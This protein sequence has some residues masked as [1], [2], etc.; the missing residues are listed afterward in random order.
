[1]LWPQQ[2]PPQDRTVR[3]ARWVPLRTGRRRL[4][5][6]RHRCWP[7]L[8]ALTVR[9]A[10]V[11]PTTF[12]GSADGTVDD[13]GTV[14][15]KSNDTSFVTHSVIA[16][17]F[18]FT[19][20]IGA[21]G[22]ITG[23]G[24]GVFTEAIYDAEGSWKEGPISCVVG[25]TGLPFTAEVSGHATY[26]QLTG[27]LQQ[28]QLNLKLDNAVE[29]SPDQACG[30]HYTIYAGTSTI[31][32]DSL[33]AS[34]QP[35]TFSDAVLSDHV[36]TSV[37]YD[38]GN[39]TVGSNDGT[40][41]FA[42]Q[43]S[44]SFAQTHK[45]AFQNLAY[46]EG[47]ASLAAGGIAVLCTVAPE[48]VFS[49]ACGVVF[50][51]GM[52]ADGLIALFFQWLATDPVDSHYT[53]VAKPVAG[54]TPRLSSG[55]GLN[56]A[57][58]AALSAL[59]QAQV[60]EVG[61]AYAVATAVNRYSGAALADNTQWEQQQ[62]AAA[63]RYAGQLASSLATELADA[64]HAQSALADTVFRSRKVHA[65][66]IRAFQESVASHGIPDSVAADLAELE[67]PPGDSAAMRV[68]LERANPAIVAA[69]ASLLTALDFA[70]E[71]R[72]TQAAIQALRSF[73]S[74]GE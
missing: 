26:G 8:P 52:T 59:L 63:Q 19:F 66:E 61:L 46:A 35:L 51:V 25:V 50:G 15:N 71:A 54:H 62:R 24:K 9:S 48:P 58:T 57:Q 67:I 45:Q 31:L 14:T 33:A 70:A 47:A 43:P 27:Q 21:G 32:A 38:N 37:P 65:A 39:G 44:F 53:S 7:P 22:A 10:S 74:T 17:Q 55:R 60:R 40:W 34:D 42:I 41:D 49:K 72:D 36:E 64:K 56:G 30:S 5:G 29:T 4:L 13:N 3:W 2:E 68:E 23:T 6:Q 69:P 28:I 16:G 12:S 1:L 20:E 18:T 73:A 11:G